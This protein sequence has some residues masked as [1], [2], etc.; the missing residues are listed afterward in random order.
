V[1]G[2]LE[3]GAEEQ[4]SCCGGKV[5]GEVRGT[6]ASFRLGGD[7]TASQQEARVSF[8][9]HSV[10][11]GEYRWNGQDPESAG[12]LNHYYEE[13]LV[14]VLKTEPG[15]GEMAQWVRAPD[16]SSE[17]PEFKSQQTTWWLTTIRNE[18]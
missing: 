13:G 12:D 14:C 15:A 4:W 18:I 16:C 8:K 10:C 6:G 11:C 9:S 3:A 1:N 5:A 2:G 17:G 7:V